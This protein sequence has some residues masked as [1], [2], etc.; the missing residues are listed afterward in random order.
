MTNNPLTLYHYWRSSCSWR[1]RWA[2]EIKKVPYRS[3]AINLLKNEQNSAEYLKKN[4]LGF[5]PALDTGK[6][7]L[8]E[9]LAI[10][11][12]IEEKFPSPALLPSNPDERAI[13]R[14]LAL[15]IIAGTQ[16][17]QNLSVQK[18]YTT[19]EKKRLE[20]GRYFIR[21]GLSGFEKLVKNTHGEFAFKNSLTFA[22]L[23]LIPQCYNAER[24]DMNLS[25]FPIIEMIYRKCRALPS[26]VASEPVNPVE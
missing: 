6:V 16:P 21:K 2:L 9:S 3:I 5:V 20:D 17:M 24:F 10:L 23:S 14:Q 1:V 13:V 11:E 8:G 22:D 15:I 18:Y 7:I 12:W 4:P 25:E 26:C 19:D